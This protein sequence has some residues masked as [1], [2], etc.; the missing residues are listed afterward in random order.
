MDNIGLGSLQLHY[1]TIYTT[2]FFL[3][4]I[5]FYMIRSCPFPFTSLLTTIVRL[6]S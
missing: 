2:F 1:M 6:E 5:A 4:R 3:Y